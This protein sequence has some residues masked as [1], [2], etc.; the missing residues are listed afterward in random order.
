M[1]IKYCGKTA[2]RSEKELDMGKAANA[3]QEKALILSGGLDGFPLGEA[4]RDAFPKR[5]AGIRAQGHA[6]TGK[7]LE[8]AIPCARPS[9]L[10][11]TP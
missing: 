10:E 1:G 11:V 9:L 7:P 6:P 5:V 8:L 4:L 2:R 3:D